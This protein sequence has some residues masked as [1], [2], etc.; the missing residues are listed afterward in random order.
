L[1]PLA[2]SAADFRAMGVTALVSTAAVNEICSDKRQTYAF[3]KKVGVRTPRLLDPAQLLNGDGGRFP[4]FLKP[5]RGSSSIGATKIRNAGELSFFLGYVPDAIV[6][7]YAQGDEYT[8]DIL[9]DFQGRVRCV[10]PRL[11]METR[12]GEISKGM[13][14]KNRAIIAAGKRVV[15]AL[16]GAV[17]CLT[18]QCFLNPDGDVSFTEINPRFGGGF[19]LSARAGA[20]FPRWIIELLLGRQPHATIDGWDDGVLMLRY[21]EGIF[22]N[23]AAEDGC[24]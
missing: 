21:D 2:V 5:A 3:F 19:P 17:G 1:Y 15:E 16:P 6:Q 7:E 18:V 20:D 23:E 24:G 4:V 8:L 10:V 11:R 14:V 13:T 22:A 12:A 9:A